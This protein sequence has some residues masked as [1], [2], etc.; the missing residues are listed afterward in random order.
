MQPGGV[1][2]W[3]AQPDELGG[4]ECTQ[5]T[6]MLDA[7]ERER[8]HRHMHQADRRAFIVAHALRRMALGRA[9]ARDPAELRFGKG[10]HGQPVL[11]DGG[12][13]LPAFSL[14]RRRGLVACAVG[15]ASALGI[16]VETMT[17]D[18]DASLLEPFMVCDKQSTVTKED[19]YLRW[20]AL[21]A[22][23]KSRGLGLSTANPR[24]ALRAIEDVDGFE[25]LLAGGSLAAATIAS[26]LPVA[27]GHVLSIA[28]EVADNIRLVAVNELAAAA[29]GTGLQKLFQVVRTATAR[30]PRHLKTRT[31]N[32][33]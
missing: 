7:D 32:V 25:V 21:E 15:R 13:H 4:D 23:W 24:I 19:F 6:A 10:A 12:A 5:F 16:D 3:T 20:T 1:E 11:L 8:A 22:F 30:Y 31:H 9:M 18:F 28:Y 29:C 14:T 27:A 17:D 2:V 26:R 33:V